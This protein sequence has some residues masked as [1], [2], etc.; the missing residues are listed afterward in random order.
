ML[1]SCND[2]GIVCMNTMKSE[3]AL[4]VPS[5][6]AVD[7]YVRAAGNVQPMEIVFGA[8]RI[9]DAPT[10]RHLSAVRA[11]A[12]VLDRHVRAHR[13]GHVLLAPVDVVLDEARALV[14][15]PDL[16]FISNERE[17][18]VEDYVR[19]APDLIVEVLSPNPRIGRTD[20][21]IR[22]FAECNVSECWL[23]H[24]HRR[25]VAVVEF[26]NRR[27]ACRRVY[28]ASDPIESRVLPGFRESPDR[29]LAD[30]SRSHV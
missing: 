21:R 7:D 11:L 26:T 9:A 22:W 16:M 27:V 3:R 25:E 19:G 13:L 6:M 20:E 14:V 17:W 28:H 2:D 1:R 8:L 30:A 15:Q 10:P 29:L 23:V 18:I 5:S 12:R 24:Q 4:S